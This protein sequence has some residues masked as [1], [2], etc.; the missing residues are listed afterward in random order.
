MR[1]G[2]EANGKR[3]IPT[4]IWRLDATRS[5]LLAAKTMTLWIIKNTDA[6][7]AWVAVESDAHNDARVISWRGAY[8]GPSAKCNGT[9]IEARLTGAA[10]EGIRTEG[11]FPGVGTFTEMCTLSD[12]GRMICSG[13]VATPNGMLEYLENFEWICASPHPLQFPS[14][15]TDKP[16]GSQ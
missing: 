9:D 11:T 3:P 8:N 5:K 10:S 1:A 4:G 2:D 7:L 15:S 6:E 12:N 13:Q 16:A 14:D